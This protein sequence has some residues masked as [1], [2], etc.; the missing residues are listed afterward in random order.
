MYTTEKQQRQ[1]LTPSPRTVQQRLAG[2][3]G[4]ECVGLKEVRFGGNLGVGR[5]VQCPSGG[6]EPVPACVLSGLPL[7]PSSVV[8]GHHRSILS[9]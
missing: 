7:P 6:R 8:W 9:I 2:Q 1:A 3:G 5:R 4:S